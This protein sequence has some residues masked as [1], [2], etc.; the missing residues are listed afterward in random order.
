MKVVIINKSDSVGGAAVVS[1]RLMKALR[2][3]R[4]D[5]W[6]L[7]VDSNDTSDGHVCSYS[8]TIADK[9]AFLAERADFSQQW[10]FA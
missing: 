4:V 5:A 3:A 8:S 9:A 1:L 7:V 10:V 2:S 6:L